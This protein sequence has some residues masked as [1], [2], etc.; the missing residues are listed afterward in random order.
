MSKNRA[1]EFRFWDEDKQSFVS[2]IRHDSF[3]TGINDFFKNTQRFTAQQFTGL[4]DK[5]G[6][7]I[8]EGDIASYQDGR[9]TRNGEVVMSAH[10]GASVILHKHKHFDST[11]HLRNFSTRTERNNAD[12]FDLT[13]I[14]NIFE[15]PEL[16]K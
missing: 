6:K 15:N 10:S 5:N 9:E 3:F 8:F 1:I 11:S 14:G 12:Y 4:K 7:K 13:V 2:D 16:L